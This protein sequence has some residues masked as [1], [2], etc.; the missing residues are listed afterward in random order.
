MPAP[1]DFG[2]DQGDAA[3]GPP[4]IQFGS[5]TPVIQ[6][7]PQQL[8]PHN[9]STLPAPT[10]LN[11]GPPPP[12]SLNTPPPYPNTGPQSLGPPQQ[13]APGSSGAGFM[14]M[15]HRVS[16]AQ[17]D[18]RSDAPRTLRRVGDPQARRDSNCAQTHE[19]QERAHNL[20]LRE[21]TLSSRPSAS[22]SSRRAP[23]VS[24]SDQVGPP[25]CNIAER[26][27]NGHPRL[28]AGGASDFGD[29]SNYGRSESDDNDPSKIK[30]NNTKESIHQAQA[31]QKRNKGLLGKPGRAVERPAAATLGIWS[32]LHYDMVPEAQ[33]LIQ[34]VLAGYPRARAMFEYCA[35]S[36][37]RTRWS[38]ARPVS[39]TWKKAAALASG[40]AQHTAPPHPGMGVVAPM[41][42]ADMDDPMP[43]PDDR[44]D[45]PFERSYLGESPPPEGC[46]PSD[47][48]SPA[49]SLTLV[50]DAVSRR[51]PRL[52]ALGARM[53]NG[54]WPT[55]A[56]H[57][58]TRMMP[59]HVRALRFVEFLAL[60]G[61][62]TS[63]DRGRFL[64]ILIHGFS[65]F[66]LYERRIQRGQWVGDT[67]PLE[68]YPFE[69]DENMGMSQVLSW[70]HQHG[71]IPGS[72]DALAMFEYAN[73]ERNRLESNAEPG[74]QQFA[75][76]LPHTPTDVLN[77][78]DRLI[79][80]WR[81]M[82]H[83]PVRRGV[84]TNYPQFP[85]A[86]PCDPNPALAPAPAVTQLNPPPPATPG[87]SSDVKMK[88]AEEG[89]IS[90]RDTP[91]L[92]APSAHEARAEEIGPSTSTDEL[93][94]AANVPLPE[95]TDDWES[96]YEKGAAGKPEGGNATPK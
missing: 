16:S 77:W 85:G 50:L 5:S 64:A 69:C 43:A 23:S 58:G 71:L 68:H 57:H 30:N 47:A 41:T 13:P 32:D 21:R 96:V 89:E 33:S 83:G 10:P 92:G 28:P 6:P 70:V 55:E 8:Q 17:H 75:G 20:Q 61:N 22:S 62:G 46:D 56:N 35:T 82:R 54:R 80:D 88:L 3:G 12:L 78:P 84:Y 59:N 25:D 14:S 7:G 36:T 11:A 95:D 74:G 81:L 18:R 27:P 45:D 1:P 79:S 42:A 24:T 73:S 94:R 66:G 90:E 51:S 53:I 2:A 44:Q 40:L 15:Q 63:P 93:L 91:E 31:V 39:S 48:R 34:W 67:L 38:C 52:W 49:A 29:E 19:L 26:G 65:V 86:P 37:G 72:P 60:L 87:P 76:M 9:Q 4:A